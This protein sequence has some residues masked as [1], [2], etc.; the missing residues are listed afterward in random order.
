MTFWEMELVPSCLLK[1]R[2]QTFLGKTYFHLGPQAEALSGPP[3]LLV[4]SHPSSPYSLTYDSQAAALPEMDSVSRAQPPRP[5]SKQPPSAERSWDSGR[6][7]AFWTSRLRSP[8]PCFRH[9]GTLPELVQGPGQ[10]GKQTQCEVQSQDRYGPLSGREDDR[11]QE[12]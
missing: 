8:Q 2:T 4:G 6:G 5:T 9:P 12:H 10:W 11:C 1:T 7:R 3:P